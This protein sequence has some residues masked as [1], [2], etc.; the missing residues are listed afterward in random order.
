MIQD[1]HMNWKFFVG[2]CILTVGLLLKTGVPLAPLAGGLL[3][4]G[5]VTWKLQRRTNGMPR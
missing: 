3:I 4:A 2:A 1:V 5:L